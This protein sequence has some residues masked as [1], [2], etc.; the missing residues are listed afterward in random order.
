MTA[1]RDAPP[2]GRRT[3]DGVNPGTHG[4]RVASC[5]AGDGPAQD[6][7]GRTGEQAG[8]GPCAPRFARLTAFPSGAGYAGEPC[9]TW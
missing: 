2:G 4:D 5:V 7:G 1:I 3:N 6:R 9:L 8:N